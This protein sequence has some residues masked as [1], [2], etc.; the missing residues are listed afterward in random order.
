LIERLLVGAQRLHRPIER[1][2]C[3][4]VESGADVPSMDPAFLCFVAYRKHQRAKVLSRP[5]WFSVT[6]DH[7]LL[8]MHS[9]ELQPLARSLARIVETCSTLG[10][11]ALFASSLRLGELALA[12]LGNVLTE[13]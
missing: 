5:A 2:Q 7:Y 10:D 12:T 1:L 3:R 4:L 6:D 8:L 9:L 11:Y 13:T